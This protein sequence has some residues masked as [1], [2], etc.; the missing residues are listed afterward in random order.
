MSNLI[1]PAARKN[2]TQPCPAC[3]T[4]VC[5]DC[6]HRRA[7]ANSF[8]EKPQRCPSCQS[9]NGRMESSRHRASRAD[10]HESSYRSSLAAGLAPR[11]PLDTAP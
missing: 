10:D 5:E 2:K 1:A 8:S 6:G 3:G 11:Y 9:L 4:W 7:G